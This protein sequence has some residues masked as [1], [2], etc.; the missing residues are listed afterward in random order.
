MIVIGRDD[1]MNAVVMRRG[2][3]WR[4]KQ[5]KAVAGE[6]TQP[7]GMNAVVMRRVCSWRES[8]RRI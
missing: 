5:K 8:N 3:S 2:C 7:G 4:E 6:G 1:Q